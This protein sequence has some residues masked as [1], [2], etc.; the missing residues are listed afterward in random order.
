MEDS[1]NLQVLITFSALYR[2]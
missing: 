1:K 2:R